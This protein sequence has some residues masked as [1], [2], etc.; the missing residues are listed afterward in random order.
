MLATG[1]LYAR[2]STQE[3]KTL[4]PSDRGVASGC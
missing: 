2:N 4:E 3:A 1:A